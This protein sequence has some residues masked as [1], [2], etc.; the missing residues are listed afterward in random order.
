MISMGSSSHA[1][2]PSD[3][4]GTDRRDGRIDLGVGDLVVDESYRHGVDPDGAY[5]DDEWSTIYG[6]GGAQPVPS[7]LSDRYRRPRFRPYPSAMLAWML[8]LGSLVLFPL[9]LGAVPLAVYAALKG[10]RWA[11]L[12]AI[13]AVVCATASFAIW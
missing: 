1:S 7:V 8:A 2:T 4:P 3:P 11:W 6:A 9:V 13:V 5:S 12:A 10:N